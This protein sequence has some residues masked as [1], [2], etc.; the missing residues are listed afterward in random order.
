MIENGWI[1]GRT[2]AIFAVEVDDRRLY[3]MLEK[4]VI[5]GLRFLFD[6]EFSLVLCTIKL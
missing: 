4:A 2:S 3:F 5:V 1:E 6:N